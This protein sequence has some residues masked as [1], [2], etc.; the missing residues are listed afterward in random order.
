M[1][2]AGDPAEKRAT[3][4]G[5]PLPGETGRAMTPDGYFL[6]GDLAV[7]DEDGF[8][9]ILG[10]RKELII[11]GGTH[12]TPREVEDV[13]RTHPGGGCDRD[14]RRAQGVLSRTSG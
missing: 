7:I 11:R 12:V 3:T 5:R 6:T 8:L 1:T 4:V 13:L 10:R 14:R 9:Q 2:R